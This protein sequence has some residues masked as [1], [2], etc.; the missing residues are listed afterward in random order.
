[1]PLKFP[2]HP[3]NKVKNKM[4][5]KNLPQLNGMVNLLSFLKGKLVIDEKD[6]PKEY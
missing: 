5:I 1:M 3:R 6:N 2:Q 4:K